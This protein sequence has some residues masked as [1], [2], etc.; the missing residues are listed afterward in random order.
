MAKKALVSTIESRGK[1]NSGYRVLEV[2]DTANTFEVHS[3]KSTMERL[4]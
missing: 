2:V 3:N 1:D 4:C